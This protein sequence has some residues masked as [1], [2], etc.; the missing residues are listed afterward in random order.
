M[1]DTFTRFDSFVIGIFVGFV[2]CMLF[3]FL[4]ATTPS[5]MNKQWEKEVIKRGLGEYK[6]D[7]DKKVTFVWKNQ[8]ISK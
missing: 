5:Q 8:N 3:S 7:A 1:N 6:V 4:L 2:I